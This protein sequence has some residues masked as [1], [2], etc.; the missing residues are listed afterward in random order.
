MSKI[1]D[2][3]NSKPVE[4]LTSFFAEIVGKPLVDGAGFLYADAIRTKRIANTFNLEQKYNVVRSQEIAPTTL[5]FGYKLLEKASLEED[6]YL[7]SKWAELLANATDGNFSGKVRKIYIEILD[8]LEPEDV[9]NFEGMNKHL[10]NN[11]LGLDANLRSP[12]NSLSFKESLNVLLSQGLIT[13]GVSIT[14]GIE[15][16]GMSPTTFH[17]LDQFKVTELGV[18]FY[19]AVTRS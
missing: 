6:D 16:G 13:Y 17:G 1:A 19:K 18:A 5:G 11:Q 7:L 4:G 12:N 9:R 10:L 3:L 14:R 2:V 15:L 8:K